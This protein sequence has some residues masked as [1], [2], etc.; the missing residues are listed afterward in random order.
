MTGLE[1]VGL[2]VWAII[3]LIVF[4]WGISWFIGG[5]ILG[6]FTGKK[7]DRNMCW[8]VSVIL[9]GISFYSAHL[10]FNTL[11]FHMVPN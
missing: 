2:V 8:I 5:A 7:I 10:W 11:P 6:Q 9:F 3:N 1:I 4:A